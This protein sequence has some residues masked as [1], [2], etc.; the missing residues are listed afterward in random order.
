MQKPAEIDVVRRAYELWE[1]AESLTAEIRNF[2][3]SRTG[4][5]TSRGTAIPN[6]RVSTPSTA[7]VRLR[8]LGLSDYDRNQDVFIC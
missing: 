8:N 1:Q 7:S 6:S 4:M 5:Q 2:I 3:I